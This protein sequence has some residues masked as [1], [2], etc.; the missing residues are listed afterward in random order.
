VIKR[1][2]ADCSMRDF[3]TGVTLPVGD[4]PFK[5]RFA[6][7]RRFEAIDDLMIPLDVHYGKRLSKAD[8][9][10]VF[11]GRKLVSLWDMTVI[12][13]GGIMDALLHLDGEINYHLLASADSVVFTPNQKQRLVMALKVLEAHCQ[14]Q[15][16]EK[17]LTR[18][19]ELI[20]ELEYVPEAPWTDFDKE[21]FEPKSDLIFKGCDA[22]KLLLFKELEGRKLAFIPAD[23]HRFLEPDLFGEVVGAAFPS[24]HPEIK[25]AGNCLA[26]DLPN[27][28]IFHLMRVAE[29]GLRG[30]ARRLRVSLPFHIEYATWGEVVRAINGRL[31]T[32]KNKTAAQDRKAKFYGGLVLDIRVFSYL[33]RNPIMHTREWYVDHDAEKAFDSVRDFMQQLGAKGIRE[34][35][36]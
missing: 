19:A 14:K 9:V 7:A 12:L 34:K 10:M 28:A 32:L 5:T 4:G 35:S 2:V 17:T 15:Q 29:L 16:L 25:D 18:I 21:H 26:A 24:A 20:R 11:K 22:V 3:R 23:K 6:C 30:L 1:I 13:A 27:A 8:I 36:K 33:W 31:D